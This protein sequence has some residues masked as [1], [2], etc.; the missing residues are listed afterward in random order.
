MFFLLE[1]HSVPALTHQAIGR[2]YR[3][4]QTRDVSVHRFVME[5][6]QEKDL[7]KAAKSTIREPHWKLALKDVLCELMANLELGLIHIIFE[8][9][10]SPQI[11]PEDIRSPEVP[12]F[13][14]ENM[15]E[16]K[17]TN[18]QTKFKVGYKRHRT[19]KR[20]NEN[21]WEDSDENPF[22][23]EEDGF[24]ISKHLKEGTYPSDL[25]PKLKYPKL[26][27][28][29]RRILPIRKTR[30]KINYQELDS[31]EDMT[32]EEEK[33]KK[34]KRKQVSRPTKREGQTQEDQ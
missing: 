1:P 28:F 4:G 12:T 18:K 24:E 23:T 3:M 21:N 26:N 14:S 9:T 5:D 13:A 31:E 17:K 27:E 2:A 15:E 6:T 22:E 7:Y 8:Y 32:S 19:T 11:S 29:N 16:E 20:A 30:R 25:Y 10:Q 33:G 34:R